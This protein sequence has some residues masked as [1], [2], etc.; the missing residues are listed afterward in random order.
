MVYGI[1]VTLLS[2]ALTLGSLQ[3]VQAAQSDSATIYIRVVDSSGNALSEAAVSVSLRSP[4][5]AVLTQRTDAHGQTTFRLAPGK[6]DVVAR[7][8]GFAIS[9]DTL[10]VVA[11]ATDTLVARLRL[12]PFTIAQLNEDRMMRDTSQP[13]LVITQA[14]Q[15]PAAR[16][17]GVDSLLVNPQSVTVT[18]YRSSPNTPAG[19]FGTVFRRGSFVVLDLFNDD[20]SAIGA[21]VSCVR[22]RAVITGLP[23]GTLSLV[24]RHM[25]NGGTRPLMTTPLDTRR[26]NAAAITP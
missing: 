19:V 14:D 15:R 18:G 26:I 3:S 23:Q 16:C 2:A 8:I 22:W 5:A 24:V 11:R 25:D 20:P 1:R 21:M 10:P 9:R 4:R 17:V 6:Y 12:D 13:H 7:R